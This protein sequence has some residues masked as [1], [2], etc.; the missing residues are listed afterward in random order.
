MFNGF[1]LRYFSPYLRCSFLRASVRN[2]KNSAR[3]TYFSPKTLSHLSEI[4][5][6]SYPME[7]RQTTRLRLSFGIPA[8]GGGEGGGGA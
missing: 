7:T 3:E 4:S 8:R 5:V 2:V 1:I 6:I